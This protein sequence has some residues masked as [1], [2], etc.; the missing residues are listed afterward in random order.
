VGLISGATFATGVVANAAGPADIE[1]SARPADVATATVDVLKG[2]RSGDLA[3]EAHG[4]GQDK[5]RLSIKNQSKRRLNVII[6]PGLV[7]ASKTAQGAGGGRGPQSMGLGA[8]NSRDG[9][10]GGFAAAPAAAQAGL[11]SIP[12]SDENATGRV[13]VPVG[14]TIT[15]SVPAV[16]LNYGLKPPTARD[17]FI[18]EDVSDFSNDPRV[19]KALRSL[20]TFG[21][22]IGVAQAA[23]WRV[24]NDLP[25]DTMIQEAG[26]VFNVQE[27]ALAMRFVELLDASESPELVDISSLKDSRIFIRVRGEGK[28]ATDAKRISG[29][30]DGLKLMGLPVQATTA[31]TVPNATAPAL[32][33][34]V[35]LTDSK[36]GETR[37][38]V[39]LSTC[40]EPNA[41]VPVGR[42]AFRD[43]SS[44]A[45]LDG[46]R[47]VQT[48]DEVVSSNLVTV[49]PVRHSVTSTTI[50]VENRLPFTIS[51]MV[52]RAGNSSGA[53]AVPFDGL[54]VGPA[55]SALLSLQASTAS[56]VEHVELNGL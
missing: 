12:V 50:K 43:N 10:F 20:A 30:L 6:P 34:N 29:Q 27:V 8:V 52:V 7:A 49:K 9:A 28:L 23:M 39:A 42:V 45:V 46:L 25:F 47:L 44:I 24:C 16:C 38:R 5:V 1:A 4:Q 17:T 48:L 32:F 13:T 14:E 56:M 19:A 22:S 3:V 31:D 41:W 53:P 26:K 33:L 51:K 54:G 15:L 37:G 40:S 11:R 55:K 36:T 35:M 2:S 18:L 21:T